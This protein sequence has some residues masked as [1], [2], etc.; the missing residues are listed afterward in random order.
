M[1]IKIILVSVLLLL[2]AAFVFG[3]GKGLISPPLKSEL[4]T[5]TI[6]KITFIHYEK[7]NGRSA[8][9]WDYTEDDFR[10]IMGGA[11][12]LDTISYEVN[13]AG[14]G[15]EDSEL[16]STL[17]ASSE[18]WDEETGFELFDA[19]SLTEY[20]LIGYDETNRI[21][22]SDLSPGVIAV[23]HLYIDPAIKE[24]VEFDVEFNTFY[25]WSTDEIC[26]EGA[27]DLQ[28]IGTHEFG[29]NGLDDLRPLKDW[30]LTMYA[31]SDLEEIHKRDLGTG[32]ILGIQKLYGE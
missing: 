6:E 2:M 15:L 1:R 3:C 29:H 32:D 8:P 19:P 11:K 4:G 13:P 16:L 27:M 28:N 24:I 5:P 22:W 31:Y 20:S 25:T 14:S 23:T 21:V 10:L 12:W 7:S 9:P 17:G 26:A 18:T 30:A